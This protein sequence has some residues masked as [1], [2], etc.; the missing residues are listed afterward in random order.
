MFFIE[1]RQRAADNRYSV[2]VVR[3]R[4]LS[5]LDSFQIRNRKSLTTP[6][7]LVARHSTR[8]LVS[9]HRGGPLGTGR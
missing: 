6:S 3:G 9:R 8:Q 7:T 4:R 1:C 2:N 5:T